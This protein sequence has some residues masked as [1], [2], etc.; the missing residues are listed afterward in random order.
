MSGNLSNITTASPASIARQPGA[1]RTRPMMPITFGRMAP[2]TP[3]ASQA[4]QSLAKANNV[5][6][7]KGAT[8]A[9]DSAFIVQQ[10]NGK[11]VAF[12]GFSGGQDVGFD[13]A[14]KIFSA[15]DLKISQSNAQIIPGFTVADF[16]NWLKVRERW[17]TSPDGL[18]VKSLIREEKQ[19]STKFE[20][21]LART[22]NVAL[23]ENQSGQPKASMD[24]IT[25]DGVS[26]ENAKK[27][28]EQRRIQ[29]KLDEQ[30]KRSRSCETN[31]KVSI[32]P[33]IVDTNKRI[34]VVTTSTRAITTETGKQP[35]F[36]AQAEVKLNQIVEVQ[37]GD[38]V[39]ASSGGPISAGFPNNPIVVTTTTIVPKSTNLKIKVTT[40]QNHCR[41]DRDGQ[42]LQAKT[43]SLLVTGEQAQVI[44]SG[45]GGDMS[46]GTIKYKLR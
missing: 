8:F 22:V 23:K 43:N 44:M 26:F 6:I 35:N 7:I 19:L 30:E 11:T 10:M 1:G 33:S 4:A 12:V 3:A 42:K 37:P 18:E 5:P 36:A 28:E 24:G 34:V 16:S 39:V 31:T 17:A 32:Q 41:F 45:G 13:F 15:K 46:S 29:A 27:A 38:T 9:S 20:V 25:P 40:P 14:K 21:A 2:L